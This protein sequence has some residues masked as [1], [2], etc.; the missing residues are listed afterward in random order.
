MKI[1]SVEIKELEALHSS[2]KVH[3][4]DLEKELEQL[5]K[6]EDANVVML[7]SRR[8]LEV[9]ITDL[10]KGELNRPRG[11]EPLK[12]IIDKLQK[13]KKV[14]AHILTSMHGLNDLST[15]GT[16]PRE[17]DPEQ[18]KPVLNNLTIIIK[19]YLKYKTE[20][21]EIKAEAEEREKVQGTGYKVQGT[22]KEDTRDQ[23]FKGSSGHG[24]RVQRLESQDGGPA[25]T[26]AKLKENKVTGQI[27]KTWKKTTMIISGILIVAL[28]LYIVFDQFNFFRKDKFEDIRNP[29]GKISIAVM[30]F[31][32]QTGDTTLNWFQRGI[33]S[34]IIN[35][36]GN[37]SELA[38]LDDQTM[39]EAIESMNQIYT[40]GISPS[41]A[42]EVAKK[43]KAE[44]YISGSFQGRE[45]TY[46]ILVNLVNTENGNIIWTNKVEGN[47]K[48]S[49]YLNMADSLCNEIKNYLEIKA[50]EDIADYDFRE[51]Y[52]KSAE[53]YR[54][55]IE[56]MNLVLNQNY[57]SG[58]QSL[59][60]ALEIDS[61]FT[62]ASFYLAN[63]Y[64][65]LG[66]WEQ[67]FIWTKKT[68]LDKDRVPPKYQLWIELWY[69]C[70]FS[71]NPQEIG[72]Y[73]DLL[74]E[75]G[76]NT[77]LFWSDL[78]VTYFD[79]LQQYEKANSAFEKVIELN[80]ERG[81]EWKFL[82]VWDRF[83]QSLHKAGNHER[84]KEIS[85]IALNVLPN[86]SNWFYYRMAICALSQGKTAEANEV[87]VK[88]RAKHKELGT[89]E[90][91]LEL[92]L[93]QMYEQANV[94]EEAEMHFR[95][96]YELNPQSNGWIG[97][98]ARFLIYNEIN[99]NEGL[100]LIRKVL[101]ISPESEIFLQLKGWAL[102]KQGKYEE[103]VQLLSEIWDKN[104]GFNT[105][106]YNQ[107]NE[108]RQALA[109]QNKS[110]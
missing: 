106:L 69:A 93:G 98:L 86:N 43:V 39:F 17:F 54:Y 26:E 29:E 81:S 107:L 104:T 11:T 19:W 9:I 63:A 5:I 16:H 102:Y 56:G 103:S 85:N 90:K 40:A 105:E 94:M 57:E 30:P 80:L 25:E 83:I 88:Y 23:G 41:V 60:K 64:S 55:F 24:E 79:F 27:S 21:L 70:Y 22:G 101:E 15:Y 75:S 36:L 65:Y 45:D 34:L 109:N 100:E 47:L 4:T 53:A 71:K 2:L 76:I 92:Y 51:A 82:P 59:I 110:R 62:F 8:C 7:Y 96:A 58:I 89:P 3:S 6:T 33:S 38:V 18:V 48:S 66:Q 14:P 72:R 13:E 97:E 20:K 77:R 35:G 1:W 10:C 67:C 50:L 99:V 91:N 31:E 37:S 74:A 108:A 73:C 87:L 52:P 68:Y 49:G 12:G 42:R 95:K 46:W 84:E 78:G 61:T 28:V 32:N 44:T